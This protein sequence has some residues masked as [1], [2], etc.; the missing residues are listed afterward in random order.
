M[1]RTSS[2][3]IADALIALA[4]GVLTVDTDRLITFAN[5]SAKALF[6]PLDPVGLGI[7][8]LFGLAGASNGGE[9]AAAV[10][11]GIASRP[12]RIGLA[13]GRTLDG[14]SRPL[15]SGG[16]VVTLLDVTGYLHDA[17]TA[18]RDALTGLASRAK[19]HH[20]L[21]ELLAQSQRS[22]TSLGVICVDLNRFNAVNDTLGR[23]VGDALLVKVAERLR[24]AA[25]QTDMVARLGGDEFAILQAHSQQP[26]AAEALARRLVDLIGRSY[27]VAGHAVNID[28]SVGVALSPGDGD[29]ADT[30]LKNSA[31][32]LHRAK[33]ER[34]G[35][36]RFFQTGMDAERQ[37][38][39]RLEIELRRA[40]ALKQLELAYQPQIQLASGAVVGF[41]ALLRW[42][43]PERGLVSPAEFIPVAEEI[44][45]ISQIGEFVLRTA[46]REAASWPRPVSIAVNVSPVQFLGT[47]LVQTVTSALSAASLDPARLDLEITEGALLG[48]TATVLQALHAF[49]ALGVRISMDDFGTG[50]SSLGYLQKFPFDK[51]KIDQ[52]FVRGSD[53]RADGA[54]IVRA[55]A[56]LGLSLGMKTTAEGVE[57]PDQLARMQIAGCSEVQGYLTGRP[58]PGSDVAALL[59]RPAPLTDRTGAG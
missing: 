56:A 43:S 30:L 54:A 40:L 22:G 42:R 26:Q 35:E 39:R 1:Q 55:V 8:S 23:A 3:G 48:N 33:T 37:A 51:I 19:L 7:G 49:K 32:A 4:T 18:G 31:L 13:D 50:Y 29:S 15:P 20:R 46:C 36:V 34:H 11:S 12:T 27:V 28:A 59:S 44:G 41:E 21:V 57:T 10:E 16:A 52:S 58:M 6:A 47:D 17:E 25:C 24:G 2:G 38:R 5:P 53:S 14:R 9:L 45:L